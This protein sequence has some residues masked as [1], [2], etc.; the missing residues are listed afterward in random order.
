MKISITKF[1]NIQD[2]INIT[3]NGNSTPM[4]ETEKIKLIKIINEHRDC[5][6]TLDLADCNE[7][8]YEFIK[9]QI[10]L[11][12]K[13]AFIEC[14]NRN[15]IRYLN[16]IRNNFENF[17]LRIRTMHEY[18]ELCK[19]IQ[20][21]KKLEIPFELYKG[22]KNKLNGTSDEPSM[23]I[24]LNNFRFLSMETIEEIEKDPSAK[25]IVINSE[26]IKG[27]HLR[28][29]LTLEETKKVYNELMEYKILSSNGKND[30]EKFFNAYYIIGK[31]IKYDFDSDGEPSR[32]G[33]A[34]SLKGAIL[35]KRCV[36]EGYA[37]ALS[38]LLNLLD[39]KN[40]CVVGVDSN[41]KNK[42]MHIWNQVE[43]NGRWYNCDITNDSVNIQ[44]NKKL[45]YCLLSDKENFL[46]KCI[47]SNAKECSHILRIEEEEAER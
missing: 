23:I 47:S 4:Q 38:Q 10:I 11:N 29:F 25:G 20:N 5:D 28:N 42:K 19:V 34:H 37:Y 21:K 9:R 7:T 17:Y 27:V 35:N 39:I 45:E 44:E 2:D 22:I 41:K 30:M 40:E 18:D 6:I 46:Y 43:I 33:I 13:I 31:N 16:V 32:E 1:D 26:D 3:I 14:D 15:E 36:C 12:K 8:Y 24:D